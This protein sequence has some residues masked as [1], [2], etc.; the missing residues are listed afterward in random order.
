MEMAD[1]SGDQCEAKGGGVDGRKDEQT[2]VRAAA[3]TTRVEQQTPALQGGSR[4][5]RD[6]SPVP[7]SCSEWRMD[8]LARASNGRE[9][10]VFG[11]KWA[12][13][14]GECEGHGRSPRKRPNK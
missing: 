5:S 9:V 6:A 12:E 7:S 2:S 10:K 14:G 13:K 8:D 1:T 3:R 11:G 4:E